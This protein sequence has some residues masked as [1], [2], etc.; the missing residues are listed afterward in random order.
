MSNAPQM[1]RNTV[2]DKLAADQLVLGLSVRVVR[3][4]DAAKIAKAADHDFLF[5]DMEHSGLSF[6]TV[7]DM[8]V[9][10]IDTG[11]TPIVRVIG[12]DHWLSSRVLDCGAMGVVVPHVDNAAEAKRA[13]DACKYPPIG[14]RSMSA[15]FPHFD[16]QTVAP[17]DAARIHNENILVA[18]MVETEEAINNVDEIAATEGVDVVHIGTNDLLSELGMPGQ[19]DHPKVA[20]MYQKVI[21]ACKKHGKHAGLGGVRDPALCKRYLQLG[22]RFMTTNSD[23]AFL[24][25]GASQRAAEMRELAL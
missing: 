10:A 7:I 23:I 5:I 16:Y 18:V 25:A 21:A 4:P 14:H 17:A 2:K 1:H 20:E 9:A 12:H 24:L 13:V 22:F 19:F 3:T 11:I 6:E 15:A 8:S